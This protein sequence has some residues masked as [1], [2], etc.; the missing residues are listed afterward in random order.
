MVIL[1]FVIIDGSSVSFVGSLICPHVALELTCHSKY[2][3]SSMSST[4][5]VSPKHAKQS[6]SANHASTR[7]GQ[8]IEETRSNPINIRVRSQKMLQRKSKEKAEGN[9]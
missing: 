1:A 4:V 6:K 7:Q 3:M 5:D 8:G 2:S 9:W